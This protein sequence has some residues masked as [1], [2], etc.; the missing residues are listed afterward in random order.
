MSGFADAMGRLGW[1][2]DRDGDDRRRRD[3]GAARLTGAQATALSDA[4]AAA[5]EGWAADFSRELEA[6]ARRL[7]ARP[8][9]DPVPDPHALTER[10]GP[11][12]IE[13]TCACGDFDGWYNGPRS[14]AYVLADHRRHREDAATGGPLRVRSERAD[15][16]KE[17]E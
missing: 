8:H 10:P 2:R 12:G 15:S 5:Y 16:P 9:P 6:E 1:G 4:I 13:V 3:M 14:R 17:L 7:A 11:H